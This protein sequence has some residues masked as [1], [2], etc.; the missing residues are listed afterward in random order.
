M[1]DIHG[2]A[3]SVHF[4]NQ[5]RNGLMRGVHG[6]RERQLATPVT[7]RSVADH[8]CRAEEYATGRDG[9]RET[10]LD[11]KFR[12]TGA[13][14]WMRA[15]GPRFHFEMSFPKSNQQHLAFEPWHW[16]FVGDLQSFRTFYYARFSKAADP[17]L[18]S[19]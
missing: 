12:D 11:A 1:E 3:P 2:R 13:Y 9:D 16:R 17:R 4:H 7:I 19:H 5:R 10:Q 8:L 18:S 15:N 14:Q 6:P